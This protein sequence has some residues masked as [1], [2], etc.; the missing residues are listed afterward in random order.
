MND[1]AHLLRQ[2]A[3]FAAKP[4]DVLAKL[5]KFCWDPPSTE[6][7]LVLT[8]DHFRLAL[9]RYLNGDITAEQLE[10]W[11]SSLECRDD[12]GFD[13][14]WEAVLMDVEYRLASPEINEVITPKV[15][16]AML[17]ELDGSSV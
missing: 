6:P 4:R 1:R 9:R 14:L 10:E 7:L 8:R 16:A 11:A 15:V 3:E 2:L 17:V 12:V 5:S 13:P